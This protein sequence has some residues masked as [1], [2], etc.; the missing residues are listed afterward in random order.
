MSETQQTMIQRIPSRV[1]IGF[2]LMEMWLIT[3]MSVE[4]IGLVLEVIQSNSKYA[5]EME[6]FTTNTGRRVFLIMGQDSL[7]FD[8]K[9][10]H[11]TTV[12]M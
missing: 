9:A 4:I 3:F 7:N 8:G 2:N 12:R 11:S 10:I 6:R 5:E 1:L